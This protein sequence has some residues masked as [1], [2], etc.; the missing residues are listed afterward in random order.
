M[1]DESTKGLAATWRASRW[2]SPRGEGSTSLARAPGR[3]ARWGASKEKDLK[4][5]AQSQRG[6]RR[7]GS[8]RPRRK[9]ACRPRRRSRPTR[10]RACRIAT[11]AS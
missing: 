10:G 1:I 7:L 9:G 4:L 3:P 6:A 5:N 2:R 8:R 11:G